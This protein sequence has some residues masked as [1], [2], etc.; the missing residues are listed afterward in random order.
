MIF[1]RLQ[2]Q[3]Y[4]NILCNNILTSIIAP[5]CRTEYCNIL[6][7][8]LIYCFSLSMYVPTHVRTY[9]CIQCTCTYVLVSWLR[10]RSK[11]KLCIHKPYSTGHYYY[12]ICT[13]IDIHTALTYVYACGKDILMTTDSRFLTQFYIA[14]IPYAPHLHMKLYS[15]LLYR[16]GLFRLA[17]TGHVCLVQCTNC[18]KLC[19][20]VHWCSIQYTL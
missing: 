3:Y 5:Y 7:R 10:V 15:I 16:Y 9:M 11:K 19:T 2:G 20:Y 14:K 12:I 1:A 13:Y 17:C 6:I 8:I 18:I 4:C